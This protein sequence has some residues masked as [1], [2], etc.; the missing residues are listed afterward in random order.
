M[1]C[2]LV[3][4]AEGNVSVTVLPELF[5][6]EMASP[7]RLIALLF[8][9]RLYVNTTSAG[10]IGVPLLNFTPC[11]IVNVTALPPLDHL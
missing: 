11:R 5:T 8:F 6:L 4:C 10:V 3:Y 7:A 1:D 9:T 2:K